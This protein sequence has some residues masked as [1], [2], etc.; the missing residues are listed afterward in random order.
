M[1]GGAQER[2]SDVSIRCME[3]TTAEA[4]RASFHP[5]VWAVRAK[6]D[7]KIPGFLVLTSSLCR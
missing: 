2:R 6:G 4:F 7:S 5:K 1:L 3:V